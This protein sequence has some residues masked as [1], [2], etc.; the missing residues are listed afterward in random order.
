MNQSQNIYFSLNDRSL[1]R[2]DYFL[3]DQG[4]P[5]PVE[6]LSQHYDLNSPKRIIDSF[7]MTEKSK[8]IFDGPTRELKEWLELID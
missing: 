3:D 8:G 4:V 5:D 7:T 6:C 1:E 2:Y